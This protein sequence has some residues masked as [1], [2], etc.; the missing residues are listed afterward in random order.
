[1]TSFNQN[2]CYVLKSDFPQQ[3]GLRGFYEDVIAGLSQSPKALPCKYFYDEAGSILFTDICATRDYYVT[4]TETALMEN[5]LPELAALIG[6]DVTLIEFGSGEGRK[7]RRLLETLENP[8]AYVPIDISVEILN[9]SAV[10]LKNKF[11]SVAI[12]PLVADYT[13]YLKLPRQ[14]MAMNNRKVV[15]F[16]GSTISNF[17]P[18]ESSQFFKKVNAC[19][20]PGDGFVVGVDLIKSPARLHAA[21][22]DSQGVT[23][24]FDLNLLH[25]INRELGANFKPDFFEHYAFFNPAQHRMEMHLVSLRDH[26][27]SIGNLRFHFA[28]GES[29]HT[30]NSYKFTREEIANL[31]AAYGFRNEK[32]WVDGEQLFSLNFLVKD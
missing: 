4:R 23:S 22:N 8:L 15:Y 13:Q 11:P 2:T 16:P 26:W 5:I 6:A 19:L 17:T 12:Y 3:T 20:K 32:T 9:R 7:I 29:I 18:Q 30:E 14:V 21:Y 24:Q 1:M 25:R 31:G 27:V 28:H 10:E